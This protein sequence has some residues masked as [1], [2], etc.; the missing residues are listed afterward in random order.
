MHAC[1]P[2]DGPARSQCAGGE[3][4]TDS[5]WRITTARRGDSCPLLACRG[6]NLSQLEAMRVLAIFTLVLGHASAQ[7]V[8]KLKWI[9]DYSAG[10]YVSFRIR[11]RGPSRAFQSHCIF[12]TPGRRR[13]RAP[14]LRLGDAADL[15]RVRGDRVDPGDDKSPPPLLVERPLNNQGR[16]PGA[17]TGTCPDRTGAPR[18]RMPGPDSQCNWR[19]RRPYG[20]PYRRP[21]SVQ[22]PEARSPDPGPARRPRQLASPRNPQARERG[23]RRKDCSQAHSSAVGSGSELRGRDCCAGDAPCRRTTPT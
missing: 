19:N 12:P 6:E 21:G 20:R 11:L 23:K 14:G 22:S 8:Y 4:T 15:H 7:D 17:L 16:D 3:S 1:A 13:R 18:A 2:N 10:A 9:G 5:S